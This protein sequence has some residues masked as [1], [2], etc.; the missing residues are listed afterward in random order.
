MTD[1]LP[2]QI[3]ILRLYVKDLSFESPQAPLIFR[4]QWQPEI[5]L[6][7]SEADTARA[8]WP[9]AEAVLVE[10]R[11]HHQRGDT[12]KVEALLVELE[13]RLQRATDRQE[14]H[15]FTLATAWATMSSS[16]RMPR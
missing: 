8:P 4:K 16:R 6:D 15:G 9:A 14:A 7:V 1:Q 5:K 13:R 3:G 12:A 11:F 2:L 10:A